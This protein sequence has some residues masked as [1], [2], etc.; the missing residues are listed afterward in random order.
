MGAAVHQLSGALFLSERDPDGAALRP[1]RSDALNRNEP[2]LCKQYG[3]IQRLAAFVFQYGDG[4]GA[5]PCG[6]F[7]ECRT[8]LY[9]LIMA[10]SSSAP[11]RRSPC[12]G[13]G[14]KKVNTKRGEGRTCRRHESIMSVH[15]KALWL[16]RREAEVK[17]RAGRKRLKNISIC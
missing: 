17:V 4:A 2:L 11:R 5:D 8:R 12:L 10:V 1:R 15:K 13:K 6:S 9:R 7:P 16:R 14:G 3:N